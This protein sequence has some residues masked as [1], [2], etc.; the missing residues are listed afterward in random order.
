V[1]LGVARH[2][3]FIILGVVPEL[4]S[5]RPRGVG[6]IEGLSFTARRTLQKAAP[7]P[8]SISWISGEAA[9]A[10]SSGATRS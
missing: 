7:T 9:L 3:L 4:G 2:D 6:D 1:L 8:S 10:V 5:S